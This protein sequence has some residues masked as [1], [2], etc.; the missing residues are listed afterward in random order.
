MTKWLYMSHLDICSPSYEQKKGRESNCQFDSWPLK[1]RNR[2]IPNVRSGS[3]TWRW[4]DL[5]EG[6]NFV[7]D[8]VPIRGWGEKLCSSKVSGLQP[9]TPTRDSFRTPLWESREKKAI[10]MPLPWVNAENI[11]GSMVVA[12]PE[13]G[14]WCVTWVRV[15]SWFVPTPNACKMSSNQLVL[16][17]DTGSW[18]NSLISS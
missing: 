1:V 2:P 11:I 16:V 3:A 18:P 15:N 7:L 8:V 10:R 6:Y 5:F 9:G 14:P 17:L 12:S 4:K 13:S